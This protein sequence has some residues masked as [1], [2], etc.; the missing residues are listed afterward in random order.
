MLA[1]FGDD[2][3]GIH[4]STQDNKVVVRRLFEEAWNERK[5]DLLPELLV[6]DYA[7]RERTW[8]EQVLPAFPD[9]HFS[10]EDM[11][12]EDDRVA[13][14]FVWHA[15]HL[16]AFAGIAPTGVRIEMDGIFVH[17]LVD[18]KAVDSWGFGG[19]TNIFDQIIAKISA[20]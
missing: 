8:A 3:E 19:G 1:S 20:E 15:T 2:A 11:L 17:R 10:I 5:L 18:G 9:T 16:G 14:R 4:M 7:E 13:T 12:A 6:P